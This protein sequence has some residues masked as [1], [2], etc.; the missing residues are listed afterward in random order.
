MGDSIAASLEV[1]LAFPFFCAPLVDFGDLDR[2][3][4]LVFFCDFPP[5]F[6]DCAL[7]LLDPE[8][9]GVNGPSA[10]LVAR[11]G[12]FCGV[13]DLVLAMIGLDHLLY[14]FR[15]GRKTKRRRHNGVSIS[16]TMNVR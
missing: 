15:M 2:S 1:A 13:T 16:M 12:R 14:N 7:G 9:S 8:T 5:C 3:V 4:V 11:L 6:G 10:N